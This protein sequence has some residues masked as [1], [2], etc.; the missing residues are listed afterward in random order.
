MKDQRAQV[1]GPSR[2]GA[3]R[4]RPTSI[5][6]WIDLD[7]EPDPAAYPDPSTWRTQLVQPVS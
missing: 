4:P 5:Y 1:G 6:H 2:S 3:G 7:K